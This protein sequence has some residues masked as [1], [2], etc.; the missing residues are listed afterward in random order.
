MQ[1]NQVI[2]GDCLKVMKEFPN[3][4]VDLIVTD[5]PYGDNASYGRMKKE[6]QGNG[7]PLISCLALVECYR[8]LRKNKSLYM[9]TSW[10]HLPF[11]EHFV[12]RY[13]KF[14]IRH[15]IVWKKKNFGLGYS[16][17]NQFELIMVLEKGKPSYKLN[18][19]S[20]VQESEHIVHSK[21]THP[22]QKP[23][24]IIERILRHSSKE[25]DIVLDPFCGSGSVCIACQ[26]G[27]RNWIG[28]EKA[29]YYVKMARERIGR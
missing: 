11:L 24:S 17:R 3:N 10:R 14:N 21:K 8:V 26:N 7:N 23:L 9:F 25:G 20:D 5:P 27:C 2:N 28:I 22:H 1:L 13:T 19:F 4:S 15:I 29:D 16:F 6:V 18:N 12:K